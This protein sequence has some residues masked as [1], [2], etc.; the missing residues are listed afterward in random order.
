MKRRAF[1]LR[2]NEEIL[3]AMQ[4]WANDDVRSVN[5]QIEYLLRQSLIASGRY[6]APT[7]EP[8]IEGST[9]EHEQKKALPGAKQNS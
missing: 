9:L 2:I 7:A 4:R 6:K 8:V 5:G 3:M 1:P